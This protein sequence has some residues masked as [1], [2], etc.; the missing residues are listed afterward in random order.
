MFPHTWAEDRDFCWRLTPAQTAAAHATAEQQQQAE[1]AA[2]AAARKQAAA[3]AEDVHQTLRLF[4]MDEALAQQLLVTRQGELLDLPFELS[5]DQMRFT[6]HPWSALA[7]GRS[8]TGKTTALEM[9]IYMEELRAHK[10]GVG[11]PRQ[12]LL[13]ASP[14]LAIALRRS[15]KQKMVTLQK[16]LHGGAVEAGAVAS[17]V[18]Q[19]AGD[20]GDGAPDTAAAGGVAPGRKGD[21]GGAA[22]DEGDMLDDYTVRRMQAELPNSFASLGPDHMPV[23]LTYDQLLVMLDALLPVSFHQWLRGRAQD[24]AA[25]AAAGGD[26]NGAC[27]DE[28]AGFGILAGDLNEEDV[29]LEAFV[30]AAEASHGST[31]LGSA[32]GT[33][34][35]TLSGG[36]SSSRADT[37]CVSS[38]QRCQ[39]QKRPTEAAATATKSS[40]VLVR[41]ECV[42]FQLFQAGYW[43]HFSI[44]LRR[45]LDA[46]LVF[47][48]IL[49]VIKG[50]VEAILSPTGRLS[51]AEYLRISEQRSS[52]LTR[53]QREVVYQLFLRYEQLKG[54][55][56]QYDVMDWVWHV[57]Q[58]L[59]QARSGGVLLVQPELEMAHV[60]VDEVQ[61]LTFGQLYLLR[62]GA[63]SGG[64]S[65]CESQLL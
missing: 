28:G 20:G 45:K 14:R 2:A 52:S 56:W 32:S 35:P 13:T 27:V 57:Q 4:K 53:V 5:P 65:G 54:Q 19:E 49:G 34:V 42:D 41:Y 16:Q 10:A 30:S 60:Y 37:S 38:T 1:I 43:S 8:G 51:E 24:V 47:S 6:G 64:D 7:V 15:L 29:N 44:D 50:H 11:Q 26:G 61:D 62:W 12:L 17:A 40:V 36:S 22:A 46:A 25:A 3:L 23:V 9:K 59:Q 18:V 39:Q 55:A 21:G 48:E 63:G 33:A 31:G 58:G